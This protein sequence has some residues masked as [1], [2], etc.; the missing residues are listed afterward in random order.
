[1]CDWGRATVVG[2]MKFFSLCVWIQN[3]A[4]VLS[5]AL[6]PRFAGQALDELNTDF[7]S[8]MREGSLHPAKASNPT[9]V[10]LRIIAK[11]GIVQKQQGKLVK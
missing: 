4:V 9:V 6:P 2:T 8:G 7:T 3:G 11:H 5:S 10:V 1:M